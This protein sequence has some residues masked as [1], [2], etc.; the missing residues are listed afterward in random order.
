M[1][2]ILITGAD[3]Q[4]GAYLAN[5]L[6]KKKVNIFCSVRSLNSGFNRLSKL[7]L[8]NKVKIIEANLLE[9]N[10]IDSVF[11][12]IGKIDTIYNFAAISYVPSSFNSPN[13]AFET[14]TLPVLNFLEKIRSNSHKTKFYQ[15]STSEMYG[16]I[17]SSK[18]KDEN[19]PMSPVSPYGISKLASHNLI[20]MYRESYNIF[21][22]SGILF[23]HESPL[24]GDNF[25]T[26]KI[27]KSVVR[28][29]KNIYRD[30][31][32]GNIFSTRDWGYAPE[33]VEAIYKIMQQKSPDDFVIST[34]ISYSIKDFVSFC[35]NY[36][37]IKHKW[38][39][40][41]QIYQC[42]D[43]KNNKVIFSSN[44]K[45]NLRP[46]ELHSLKGDSSK[47][48]KILKWKSKISL[49]KLIKIMID[50]ELKSI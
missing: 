38:I 16:N 11:K 23:N 49:K 39:R 44:H 9:K 42:I 24:R 30:D 34:G 25:V 14:N 17:I 37:A 15:A 35:L 3:G 43:T 8:L 6:T 18:R 48:L 47:A 26:K 45:Q 7:N 13:L 1:K 41:K 46:Y 2:N 28:Y 29:S 40:K 5:L 27:V 36:L 22:C 12:Q 19:S 33:Y 20:K 10:T 4:D 32:L 50:E 21:A 31:K